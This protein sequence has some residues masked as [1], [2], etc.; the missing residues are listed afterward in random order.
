MRGSMIRKLVQVK[1]SRVGVG[2]GVG[3]VIR[4]LVQ[5]KASPASQG[6]RSCFSYDCRTHDRR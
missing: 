1:A 4:R 5:V 6:L 2:V 3:S